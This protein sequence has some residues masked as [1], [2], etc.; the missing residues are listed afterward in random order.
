MQKSYG[1]ED[2]LG[3]S[4]IMDGCEQVM[5][6]VTNDLFPSEPELFWCEDHSSGQELFVS[7][8][9]VEGRPLIGRLVKMCN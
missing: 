2:S 1:M 6:L 9:T 8:F 5:N 7:I 4:G 3:D